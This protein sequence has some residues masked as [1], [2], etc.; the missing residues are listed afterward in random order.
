MRARRV[1]EFLVRRAA[2]LMNKRLRAN[3]VQLQ[4]ARRGLLL[5]P[6]CAVGFCMLDLCI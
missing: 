6:P 5:L 4:Q 3:L 2:L 1:Y